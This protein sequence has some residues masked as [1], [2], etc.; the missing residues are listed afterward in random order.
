MC[1]LAHPAALGLVEYRLP[2]PA[3]SDVVVWVLQLAL[4]QPVHDAAPL[5]FVAPCQGCNAGIVESL[6]PYLS[7]LRHGKHHRMKNFRAHL[8]TESSQRMYRG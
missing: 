1:Q 4:L 6:R 7:T 8:A 2:T 3:C 5:T